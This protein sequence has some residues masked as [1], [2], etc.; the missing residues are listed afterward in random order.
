MCLPCSSSLPRLHV[1]SA[2]RCP[3]ASPAAGVVVEKSSHVTLLSLDV[4]DTG[5]EG[6]R[7]RF[8]SEYITVRVSGPHCCCGGAGAA[9]EH[10][11]RVGWAP[12]NQVA[13][14]WYG[15]QPCWPAASPPLFPRPIVLPAPP[16]AAPQCTP[17][18]P[19]TRPATA[20]LSTHLTG[21]RWAGIVHVLLAAALPIPLGMHACQPCM[22][23]RRVSARVCAFAVIGS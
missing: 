17:P 7:I 15:L 9:W 5:Y 11:V 12:C 10:L 13:H 6:V 4:H 23:S 1:Q 14:S 3:H 20:T 21:W 18:S 16:R 19:T 2:L 8:N 22:P